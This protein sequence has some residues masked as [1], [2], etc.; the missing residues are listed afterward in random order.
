MPCNCDHLEPSRTEI[1]MSKVACLL[2]EFNGKKIDGCHWRG[3]HPKVYNQTY[4]RYAGD[5]DAAEM[6]QELVEKIKA[7]RVTDYSLE[8]QVWWRD[9]QKRNLDEAAKVQAEKEEQEQRNN[10]LGK[11]TDTDKKAL[12][13]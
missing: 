7:C 8:M 4:D 9:Y 13:L 6:T 5:Y 2:D 1:K 10:A 3:M 12:G 11:L